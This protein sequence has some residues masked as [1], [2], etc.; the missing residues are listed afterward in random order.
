MGSRINNKRGYFKKSTPKQTN[1]QTNKQKS[2]MG[3]KVMEIFL[4][5]ILIS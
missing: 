2:N 1:K 4:S 5:N 3:K